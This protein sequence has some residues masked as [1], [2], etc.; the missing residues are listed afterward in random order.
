MSGCWSEIEKLEGRTLC[1]LARRH[2]FD[3]VE[4]SEG[5]A[6]VRPHVRNISRQVPRR[7]VEAA[8]TDLLASGQ[9]TARQI[10]EIHASFHS[11][12]VSALL[13]ELPGITYSLNPITLYVGAAHRAQLAFE[14]DTAFIPPAPPIPPEAPPV[15][16]SSPSGRTPQPASG[17]RLA[18]A[19]V[20][21]LLRRGFEVYLPALDEGGIDCI[22]R[23]EGQAGPCWL[24]IHIE[25]R[26]VDVP[27]TKAGLF[28]G[29]EVPDPRPDGF[30]I[31][32]AGLAEVYWVV[33]SLELVKLARRHKRG[34]NKGRYT[35]NFCRRQAG[36]LVPDPQYAA[37]QDAFHR[38]GCSRTGSPAKGG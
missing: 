25:T 19:V 17:K 1:V 24:E 10:K 36:R 26:P 15:V 13:A 8:Y 14:G 20:A 6:V 21:E 4:V 23:L 35:I 22:L 5:C 33:P 38:L 2:P 7:E 29:L 9:I 34:E 27:P 16:P 12:F 3:V 11:A 18:F 37:Y 32:Y 31:F 28:A 30:F